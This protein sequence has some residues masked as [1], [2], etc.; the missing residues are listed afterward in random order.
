MY[1]LWKYLWHKYKDRLGKYAISSA[2]FLILVELSFSV[3][4][5]KETL[6]VLADPNAAKTEKAIMIAGT[7]LGIMIEGGGYGTAAN[8]ILKSTDEGID[9]AKNEGKI[10][11]NIDIVM[12]AADITVFLYPVRGTFS[13]S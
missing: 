10:I 11:K 4:D 2:T 13:S 6:K 8:K 5:V 12:I 9:L 3:Y 7:R 1:F